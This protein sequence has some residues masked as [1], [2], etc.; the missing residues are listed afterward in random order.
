MVLS[1]NYISFARLFDEQILSQ[2]IQIVNDNN[3]SLYKMTI[4]FNIILHHGSIICLFLNNYTPKRIN[5]TIVKHILEQVLFIYL[6]TNYSIISDTL[7]IKIV[8]CLKNNVQHL[9]NNFGNKYI[10]SIKTCVI[11]LCRCRI[12][13]NERSGFYACL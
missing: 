7:F 1:A 6:H 12:H 2:I 10:S 11:I 9:I 4:D 8:N 5:E 3:Q 13:C